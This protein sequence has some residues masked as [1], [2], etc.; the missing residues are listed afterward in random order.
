[1]K[2]ADIFA[3]KGDIFAGKRQDIFAKSGDRQL[4]TTLTQCD[5]RQEKPEKTKAQIKNN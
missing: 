2:A 1:M 3:Q 4:A 5:K